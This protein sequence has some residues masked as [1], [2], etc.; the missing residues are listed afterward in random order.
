M[1]SL[2]LGIGYTRKTQS[3]LLVSADVQKEEFEGIPVESVKELKTWWWAATSQGIRNCL[4]VLYFGR[5][6]FDS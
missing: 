6:V 3:L 5:N 4:S 1:Q 2:L